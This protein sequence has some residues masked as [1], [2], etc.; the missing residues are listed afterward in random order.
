MQDLWEKFFS[1][2]MAH[3]QESETAIHERCAQLRRKDFPVLDHIAPKLTA[4]MLPRGADPGTGVCIAP[5]RRFAYS[6][7]FR[8]RVALVLVIQQVQ[9]EP[10]Q[11][12]ATCKR[13]G[14]PASAI[15]RAIPLWQ[16]GDPGGFPSGS[17]GPPLFTS[18]A[19]GGTIP[20]SRTDSLSRSSPHS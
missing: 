13:P 3:F 17:T 7:S 14:A 5:P 12:R 1:L 10:V 20:I 4:C 2:W 18:S 16:I 19:S 9:T 11:N 15:L 8:D 6:R